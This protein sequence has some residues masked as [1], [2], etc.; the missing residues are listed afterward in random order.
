M[1]FKAFSS[2]KNTVTTTMQSVSHAH[3]TFDNESCRPCT[4]EPAVMQVVKNQS[5]KHFG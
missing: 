3:I 2:S 5:I 1:V 4:R